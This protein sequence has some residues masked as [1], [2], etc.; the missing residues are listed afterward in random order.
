MISKPFIKTAIEDTSTN[1][2]VPQVLGEWNMIRYTTVTAD[3]PRTTQT[4]EQKAWGVDRGY[5]DLFPITSI[6]RPQRDPGIVYS[7]LY[8]S[9]GTNYSTQNQEGVNTVKFA[10]Y[11]LNETKRTDNKKYPRCYFAGRDN[12]FQYWISSARTLA[13]T[14]ANGRTPGQFSCE[15][16]DGSRA[17]RVTI[18]F[19]TAVDANKLVAKMNT[20]IGNPQGI[21]FEVKISGSWTTVATGINCSDNG[22]VEI[23]RPAAGG[24]WTTT[25]V[26]YTTAAPNS[27]SIQGIRMSVDSMLRILPSAATENAV[28][29][30]L[31]LIEFTPR[32]VIDLSERTESYSVDNELG[33]ENGDLM[34]GSAS[35]NTGNIVFSNDDG[36][37]DTVSSQ[38][39][40]NGKL[41]EFVE[42]Q[43]NLIYNSS[44]GGTA[45]DRT[46]RQ[47][48][49]VSDNWTSESQDTTT[50]NLVDY[51][52]ALQETNAQE[53]LVTNIPAFAAIWLLCDGAGFG[54]A[55]VNRSTA[56]E[57]D[58][59]I[60]WF[61]ADP[62]KKVWEIIQ[63]IASS[64]QLAVYFDEFGRLQITTRKYLFDR[65]SE[66][67][68]GTTSDL[69]LYGVPSGA[70]LSNIIS[71]QR[72][73]SEIFNWAKVKYKAAN[74]FFTAR[75]HR[76]TTRAPMW[77]AEDPMF[78]GAAEIIQSFA[79]GATQIKVQTVDDT[80]FKYRGRFVVEDT[81]K[82]YEYD[83]KKY[84]LFGGGT[85][86]VSSDTD[87]IYA[88]EQ[89]NGI[90]PTFTGWLRLPDPAAAGINAIYYEFR[91]NWKCMKFAKDSG[92]GQNDM[93]PIKFVRRDSGG[94]KGGYLK[95]TTNFTGGSRYKI[96]KDSASYDKYDR[97]GVKFK[98]ADGD[99]P[100]IGVVIFPTGNHFA[101]G[102][103][104]SVAPQIFGP[105]PGVDG[106]RVNL[107]TLASDVNVVR[108]NGTGGE[109]QLPRTIDFVQFADYRQ[110]KTYESPRVTKT[111]WTYLEVLVTGNDKDWRF[112]V[113][114]N[115]NFVGE[116]ADKSDATLSRTKKA[117]FFVKG[118]GKVLVDKFYVVNTVGINDYKRGYLYNLSR[119][120]K[121]HSD[122]AAPGDKLFNKYL[123]HWMSR[124]S[125]ARCWVYNF[126]HGGW[127][128]AREI[129]HYKA[130]FEMPATSQEIISS[131]KNVMVSRYKKR[132]LGASFTLH[133]RSEK[134]Q[135]VNGER[136]TNVADARRNE[137]FLIAGSTL[138]LGAEQTLDYK[139]KD[140]I[141][142]FGEKTV[143]LTGTWIQRRE[144][145][146]DLGKFIR[147]RFGTQTSNYDLE[148][149]GNPLIQVGDIVSVY[150]PGKRI[151]NFTYVVT[152]VS[153]GWN[154]GL[155]TNI[156]MSMRITSPPAKN[157]TTN[158]DS[159]EANA[160]KPPG[161]TTQ[162][163]DS[164]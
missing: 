77:K 124:K 131:N 142:Q 43:V 51:S 55:D 60:E 85:V 106:D 30:S 146:E 159:V 46:V 2:A 119:K 12:V 101:G 164:V 84:Q 86:W 127:A 45:T 26:Y 126:N 99:D 162:A 62:D 100:E 143:E 149:Y 11:S 25:P 56:T 63:E 105:L 4:D 79:Q 125:D 90:R 32:L 68:S 64:F 31:E 114:I 13:K 23:Y 50:V 130:D 134:L 38:S 120:D 97:V 72:K 65:D 94:D 108:V 138:F 135:M 58:Y 144:S 92:T 19:D 89:N 53:T 80:L 157:Y 110:E 112:A 73:E 74:K 47:L 87:M 39:L 117:Q 153:N 52:K 66:L 14:D 76:R 145:A 129:A 93:A 9:W 49:M 33:M 136:E 70:H 17:L 1:N 24:T 132:P 37:L 155:D 95:I 20:H 133:N 102:Y 128:T 61:W 59:M 116:W 29:A 115:G 82:M 5:D 3:F 148:I 113:F 40:L 44:I 147:D 98:F 158:D 28:N 16:A 152:K 8:D 107:S 42:F 67:P 10:K 18:E 141:D 163:V 96:W 6:T 139:D 27:V 36:F 78:V 54:R 104:I 91:Q 121:A 122:K 71:D 160:A 75:G 154:N 123:Q 83:A 156:S 22:V 69:T 111:D 140:L 15:L 41:D 118:D 48:T 7:T 35:T 34:I 88:I 103:H 150:W 109:K 57:D 21:K 161:Y 151:A 81:G 137:T